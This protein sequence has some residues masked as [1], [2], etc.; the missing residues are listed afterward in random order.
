MSREK[1]TINRRSFLK[2]VAAA[3]A[4]SAFF[5][6]NLLAEANDVNI[7]DPNAAKPEVPK[8]PLRKF[9]K[10]DLK[11]PAFSLGVMFN[12]LE[13]QAVLRKALQLGVY[14]WDCA[15]SYANGN[16]EVGI[17]KILEKQP[18]L[19]KKM[20]LTSKSGGSSQELET[21]LH[22]SFKRTNTDYIDLYYL[23]GL[24]NASQLND[25]LRKWA[26]D[27]KKRKLIK[28]I[29]FT[30]HGNMADHLLAA[31]KTDWID[32]VMTS[33]NYNVMQDTKMQ[34]AVQACHEKGIALI[35]MKTQAQRTRQRTDKERELIE[36]FTKKGFTEGQAK[37]KIVLQ[38]ERFCSACGGVGRGSVEHLILNVDA[39]LDKTPLDKKDVAFFADYAKKNCDGYCAGCSQ[40]CESEAPDMPYVADIMRYLMYY[41]SYGDRKMA[42]DLF[43]QLPAAAKTKLLTTNYS[44]AEAKC[45]NRLPISS[46]MK[47]AAVKLA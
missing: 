10:Y 11:V 7:A 24:Y 9:G 17:G 20:F 35:A 1:D 44:L 13:Q 39:V 37:I 30:T 21:C 34:E 31:A 5:S 6:K 15:Y 29:G 43:A 12:A 14:Y 33:Y 4:G 41:N 38:D 22:E 32:A 19:R 2:T 25:D 16:A 36:Y 45:P 47:E 46:L 42:R 18:E 27:A 3:G 26:E 23:H 40:I 8:I 28:Y